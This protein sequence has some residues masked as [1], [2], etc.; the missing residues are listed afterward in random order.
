LK[1]PECFR[2]SK[3]IFS[4]VGFKT[5]WIAFENRERVSGITKWSFWSLLLYAVEG[6]VA[7][8]T[9]PLALSSIIG[10]IFCII[11]FVM[12]CLI[13]IKTSIFGDPVSGWPSLVCIICFIA[14][15]QLFCN[16]ISGLYLSKTYTQTK[17]RPIY[18]TKKFFKCKEKNDE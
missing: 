1:L 5:K 8:S 12:I 18:I 7:F 11:S 13:I 3:G 6:F 17:Q 9:F 14:S 4:W 15:I 16:G 2:F 10:I